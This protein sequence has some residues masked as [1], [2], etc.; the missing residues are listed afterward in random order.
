MHRGGL[1][2]ILHGFKKPSKERLIQSELPPYA[3]YT[4]IYRLAL[5]FQTSCVLD[6]DYVCIRNDQLDEFIEFKTSL[7]AKKRTA[8]RYIMRS[9]VNN[10]ITRIVCMLV[11]VIT[12]E[13]E[14]FS[15]FVI[16]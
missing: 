13:H 1:G 10:K 6:V 11:N 15:R 4:T 7:W 8:E 9:A 5:F 2:Q 12:S 3:P 16:G 14:S